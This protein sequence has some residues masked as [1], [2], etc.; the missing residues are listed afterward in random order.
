MQPFVHLHNQRDEAAAEGGV[1]ALGMSAHVAKDLTAQLAATPKADDAEYVSKHAGS[2]EEAVGR[3]I[4]RCVQERASDPVARLAE[5]MSEMAA[6]EPEPESAEPAT[7]P[8][9]L[10]TAIGLLYCQ[11]IVSLA[12]LIER[13]SDDPAQ[14]SRNAEQLRQ[15]TIPLLVSRGHER[16]ALPDAARAAVDAAT[17]AQVQRVDA[18]AFATMQQAPVKLYKGKEMMAFMNLT[19]SFNVITQYAAF[20]LLRKKNPGEADRLSLP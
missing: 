6:A 4:A 1:Y 13:H 15:D 19:A 10:G 17:T 18:R 5:L 14:L 8:Q 20:E 2:I 9:Q 7:D 11:A 12:A 3:A 16:Q